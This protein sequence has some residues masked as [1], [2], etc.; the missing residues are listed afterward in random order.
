M[1]TSLVS[2]LDKVVF[3]DPVMESRSCRPCLKLLMRKVV[4]M[5]TMMKSTNVGIECEA[6]TE[7]I[8]RFGLNRAKSKTII[9]LLCIGE[10]T[11]VR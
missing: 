4:P 7:Y 3:S 10:R 2:L 5:T 11:E 1:C 9:V 6:K 8:N